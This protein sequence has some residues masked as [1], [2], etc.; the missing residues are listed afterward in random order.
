AMARA[1]DA[2][3]KLFTASFPGSPLDESAAAKAVADHLGREHLV[4]PIEP[5]TAAEVLPAVQRS[6]DEPSAANSAIPLWYLSGAAAEHVKVVL[7]G[8]GGDELFM[9]Y[10]RQ[11]WASLMDRCAPIIR[12]MSGLRLLDR[13][14]TSRSRQWNYFLPNARRF[15]DSAMLGNGYERFFASVA[16]ASPAVRARIFDR[17]FLLRQD[18]HSSLSSL[19]DEYFPEE[20]RPPLSSLE[21]FV[22]GDLTVHM[23]ASL[24]QRL[25]RSSM[26]HSLEA[27]VPFLSHSF[28]DWALTI[29]PDLKLKGSVGK[30]VVRKAAEP[31]LPQGSLKGPKLG[32]KMPLS[33]WFLGGFSDFAR[34][35]WRSSGMASSG[36]FDPAGVESLFDEHRRG[37]SNHGRI[38][39]AIAMF[40][41]WWSDNA[42]PITRTAGLGLRAPRRPRSS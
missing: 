35:S 19:A 9:G 41:C 18:S 7:C 30:Y 15:R 2:P 39:Y 21:E 38:L 17:G 20:S 8:E 33:D 10:K 32:F 28:V 16:I 24:L 27:R 6:F 42:A 26:A 40:S 25:D 29:P 4:L 3:F 31:W 37:E 13:L 36:F 23:P 12:A 5:K 11:R 14:P 34:D 1:S 22:L